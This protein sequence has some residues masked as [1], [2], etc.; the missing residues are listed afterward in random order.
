[1]IGVIL[2]LYFLFVG[3][4][5]A[6]TIFK[7]KDIY[8]RGW[9]GGVIGT[10]ALM[11][12]IMIPA[13]VF[14]FSILSHIVLLVLFTVPYILLK[15][16]KKDKLFDIEL[17]CTEKYADIKTLCFVIL[18]I[19]LV[20][21]VLLTN[22]VLVPYKGGF[23]SGQS[24]YGDLQMHLSFITSIK[25]QG[26]FPPE[27]SLLSG[28]LMNYPF[29]ADMLSGSL[30]LLGTPLRWAVLIPSY[31]ISFLLVLGFYILAYTITKNRVASILAT[32]FF[33]INGG[34]G[35]AYFLDGAK[36]DRGIFTDIFTGYY[37]TPTNFNE[38]N[39]RWSNTICDMIIPQRTTMA[40]WFMLMPCLWLL[41]DALK[42][43]SRQEYI[44]LG[45][46]AGFMPMVH[47]HSFLALGIISGAMFFLYLF[48]ED[49]KKDYIINWV[50][51]GGIVLVMAAPQL[52]F[53]TFRQTVGNESFLKWQFNW[54][55]HADPYL[56]FYIKNW[57]ITALFIAP[58]FA[59]AKKDNR[60]LLVAVA[61]VFVIAELILFQPNEYDNNKLFYPVYMIAVINVSAWLVYMWDMLKNVKFRA[62]LA[63]LVILSGTVSGALTICR[64]YVSGG[65]YQTFSADA[66]KMADYIRENTDK[67]AVFLTGGEH[68]NPVCTLAGRTIYL[69]SSLYVY[70]HG[71][72]DELSKRDMNVHNAYSASYADL[73][74]FAKENNISYVY[75][76]N[77]ERHDFD[78]NEETISGL[79]LV[80][81]IGDQSLYKIQ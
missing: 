32:V 3:F 62:Y 76:S 40:G 11:S 14:G 41:I 57:G 51:F 65:Q 17:S 29:F 16:L 44:I 45:I 26:E 38:H 19:T 39:I 36:A 67:N 60:R 47:T 13:S 2:Y 68:L 18:P 61:V 8:F 46:L 37:H 20:I 81:S 22:H 69:G 23:A 53:W 35:F 55:N 15:A 31:I 42:T 21:C 75:V 70:F 72:G 48:G 9:F 64:E 5:Y 58:A 34:F 7:N 63:V 6:N 59:Y 28:T 10:V 71:M 43:K 1:M 25:E 80:Y 56:W 27:Y 12:G 30:Y 33:F 79:E 4:L 78:I 24:T 77:Y 74:D 54:V 73:V 66:V 52:V 49:N 50:I